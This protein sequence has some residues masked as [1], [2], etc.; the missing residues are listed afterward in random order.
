MAEVADH[1]AQLLHGTAEQRGGTP[2]AIGMTQAV[3]AVAMD[4][5]AARP[6]LGHGVGAG[7]RRQAG[8]EGGVE[9]RYVRHAGQLRLCRRERLETRR[10]VQRRQLCERGDPRADGF[11]EANRGSELTAVYDAVPDGGE[12]RGA[13][14]RA[15]RHQ[16][17]E[18]APDGLGVSPP[19]NLLGAWRRPSGP[20]SCSG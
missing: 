9:D 19:R 16:I 4:A 15:G 12:R 6:R 11:R 1:Q 18:R 10:V 20:T 14:A 5:P 13:R 2:A 8:M 3:E 7:R 17:A